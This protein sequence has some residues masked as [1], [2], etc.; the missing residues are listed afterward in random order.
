M[1][2]ERRHELQ[3]NELADWLMKTGQQL[4]PYQNLL[5]IAVLAGAVAFAAYSWWSRTNATHMAAAWNDMSDG[6]GSDQTE[7]IFTNIDSRVMTKVADEYPDTTVA[8]EA[9]VILADSLL[10]GGCNLRFVDRTRALQQLNVAAQ[11]YSTDKVQSRMPSMLERATYG[12]ARVNETKG[13]KEGLKAATEYYAEVVAKWPNGAFAAAA[14]ARLEDFKH[15]DTQRM[16]ESLESFDPQPAFLQEP[17]A[18]GPQPNLG[19]VP[20]E[21]PLPPAAKSK[22]APKADK[23]KAPQ[24]KA[25]LEIP[26]DLTPDTTHPQYPNTNPIGKALIGDVNIPKHAEKKSD[27]KQ[28][29]AGEPKKK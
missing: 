5:T 17:A 23:P 12:L 8:N 22:A 6:L 10:A 27:T 29:P 2:S 16:F 11:S 1:K 25:D 3:H 14:K 24:P 7:T 9:N 20:E 26:D 13:T 15:P 18:P 28:K 19:A 21:P 4:K